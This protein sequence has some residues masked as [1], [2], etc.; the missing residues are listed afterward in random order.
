MLV[1]WRL[2][3]LECVEALQFQERYSEFVAKELSIFLTPILNKRGPVQAEKQLWDRT[4]ELCKEAFKFSIMMRKS[5]EGYRCK[6]LKDEAQH[7][8][9]GLEDWV[10]SQAVDEGKNNEAGDSIAY[11]LFG[12]L[13]K[14][15]AYRGEGEKPLV[16]AEVVLEKRSS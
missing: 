11:V 1:N 9:A 12:A 16:K 14:H 2:A 10:E 6:S 4:L 8:V 3:T 5:R 7:P 13:A 15:P